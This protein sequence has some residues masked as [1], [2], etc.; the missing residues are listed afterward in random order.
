MSDENKE[1]KINVEDLPQEAKEL[2]PEEAR[3]VKG[4]VVG[5]WDGDGT[6]GLGAYSHNAQPSATKPRR[7]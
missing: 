1:S 7:P 6:A 2:T 4:G 3:E 5:D